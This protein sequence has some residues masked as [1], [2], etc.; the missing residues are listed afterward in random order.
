MAF[1]AS[2]LTAITVLT[3]A[4]RASTTFSGRGIYFSATVAFGSYS[5]FC[6]C[7][8]KALIL[9]LVFSTYNGL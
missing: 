4:R 8:K 2:G 9:F 3:L 6:H 5:I 1:Q 7:W